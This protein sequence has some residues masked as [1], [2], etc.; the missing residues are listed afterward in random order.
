MG[1]ASVEITFDFPK[2]FDRLQNNQESIERLI[3]STI[4]TQVGLRFDNEGAYNNHEKWAPLKFRQGQILS[5]SGALRKSM[6]PPG[7]EGNP[8]PGG[9]VRHEGNVMDLKTEVGTKLIYASVHNEGATIV[10]KN[11]QALRYPIGGNKFMFSKKSVIPKRNFTDMSFQD[12]EELN[13]TLANYM[14][15]LVS[16]K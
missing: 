12:T 4:Q 10:P 15:H 3:A 1:K 11:K 6:S 13:E 8:G 2:L 5:Y 7:A 16:L 9:F 14:A